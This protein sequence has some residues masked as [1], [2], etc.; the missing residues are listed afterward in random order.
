MLNIIRRLTWSRKWGCQWITI[1]LI[2]GQHYP[3]KQDV[4]GHSVAKKEDTL[5][6]LPKDLII[7]GEHMLSCNSTLYIHKYRK[8]GRSISFLI[9]RK[10]I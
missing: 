5:K 10:I 1:V 3:V 4:L 8:V 2:Q 9:L 6:T 7:Y